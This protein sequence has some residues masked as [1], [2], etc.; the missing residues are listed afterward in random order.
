[1]RASNLAY[2]SYYD[3]QASAIKRN[4]FLVA[5]KGV[6]HGRLVMAT[7]ENNI[8]EFSGLKEGP[9]AH[10]FLKDWQVLDDLIAR[11]EIGFAENYIDKKCDS[12][13]LAALLTFSLLN[14]PVLER[15]FHGKP[16][17]ALWLRLKNSL[18][19][20]SLNGSR[21]NIMEHYDLGNDFYSLWLDKSMTYSCGLFDGDESR[22][23]EE[24]QAAKYRRILNKLSAK[25][26][27]HILDIGC[28]WG[29]FAEAAAKQG[30][31]V[32]A[33]TIS[34][35]QADYA[36]ERMQKAG[37]DNLV[38]VELT[39]YREIKG[40]FDHV[41]S[42]GMIEHVGQQYWPVYFETVKKALKPGGK[43]MIQSITLDCSLFEELGSATGFIEHYI[44]PGGMLP[45]K[46]RFRM[47]AEQAGL[48]CREMFAFGEDYARTLKHWLSR[49][50]SN[51]DKVLALGFDEPFLRLWRFYLSSCIA[52]FLSKRSDVMQAEL[53]HA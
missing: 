12:D 49:F 10:L 24:A 32:T 36:K 25:P 16:L 42:I 26:G 20:N 38:S 52:S 35:E 6:E 17:Y 2:D 50:E 37:L 18:R 19:G 48:K 21:K 45:S 29:G 34:K 7:P 51:K 13:D 30:L 1:M 39:D 40:K 5:L 43:A 33:I 41:V 44:F 53:V 8:L 15:F 4:P 22:S 31:H 47:N 46:S 27:E 3:K 28:G 14:A 11:G 9:E 23:L